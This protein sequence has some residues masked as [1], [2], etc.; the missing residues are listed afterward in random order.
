MTVTRGG[1]Q[2]ATLVNTK[3]ST[4][5]NFMF[6]PDQYTIS[7]TIQ[8]TPGQQTG[9]TTAKS[10]FNQGNPRTMSLTLWFDTYIDGPSAVA[11]TAFTKPLWDMTV[12]DPAKN[13]PP[14]VE[15]HWNQLILRAV[16]TQMSEQFTLFKP[17]GT[18]VRSKVTVA[19]TEKPPDNA[20]ADPAAVAASVTAG[21]DSVQST[22]GYIASV[23][24]MTSSL[25]L[26]L[27]AASAT[28]SAANWRAVADANN[29]DNPLKISNGVSVKIPG[30]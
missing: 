17:D 22:I 6:N 5:V 18:P 4:V 19:L 14:V 8:Y 15:F 12:V 9:A 16:I 7:K 21:T 29:I 25:S 30:L 2:P 13:A 3:D 23:V 10:N 28:G 24:T 26:A 11:V 1:L 27:I 20:A